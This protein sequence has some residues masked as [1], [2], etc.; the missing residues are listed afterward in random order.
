MHGD[1]H[2]ASASG[3]TASSLIMLVERLKMENRHLCLIP[4]LGQPGK[5]RP[6]GSVFR[7]WRRNDAS[8]VH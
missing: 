5:K 4:L 8:A 2:S 3:D 7:V 6:V 1:A